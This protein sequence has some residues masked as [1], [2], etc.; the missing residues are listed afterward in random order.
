[1]QAPHSDGIWAARFTRNLLKR[2]SETLLHQVALCVPLLPCVRLR[3]TWFQLWASGYNM[4]C[5]NADFGHG[6]SSRGV[7]MINSIVDSCHIA[8]RIV[9]R[10]TDLLDVRSPTTRWE[11]ISSMLDDSLQKKIYIT[12]T[13]R[14][15]QTNEGKLP[16]IYGGETRCG[17]F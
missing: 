17:D 1:M 4:C 9:H 14:H 5:L 2:T 8:T 11:N 10:A 7:P 3:Y 15:T 13:P 6:K 16:T 12:H